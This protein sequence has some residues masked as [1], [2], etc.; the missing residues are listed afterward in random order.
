MD[1]SVEFGDSSTMWGP[2]ERAALDRY[3]STRGV[4]DAPVQAVRQ[5]GLSRTIESEIIPRLLL[6]HRE[7]PDEQLHTEDRK[8]TAAEVAEL[9][10]LAISDTVEGGLVHIAAVRERGSS[11]EAILLELFD[12]TARLLGDMWAEDLCD[13]AD[14]TIG[15]SRLHQ[16]LRILCHDDVE[17]D[18]GEASRGRIVIA[19]VP[20]DQHSFGIA[21][22][23][24]FFRNAGWDVV[25]HGRSADDLCAIVRDDWIDA[26]GLSLSG[27]VLFD[28][29]R[30]TIHALRKASR[31]PHLLVMVGGRFFNDNPRR[32]TEV[33]ADATASDAPEAVRRAEACLRTELSHG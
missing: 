25:D 30:P 3:I 8:P 22:L 15:L 4:R 12:P 13:F 31:N 17:P 26:V 19:P 7:R 16:I 14:V 5:R 11:A 32:A 27:D 18:P 24:T 9:A 33:G 6:A 23:Q 10:R 21:V 28:R 20:G 2:E 1:G 29:V